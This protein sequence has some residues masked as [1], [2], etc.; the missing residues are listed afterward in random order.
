MTRRT[1][2]YG[3]DDG[4]EKEADGDVL[5]LAGFWVGDGLYGIDIMRIKEVLQAAPHPV[6][7]V[8]HAADVI[9]GVISLRGVVIP[10]LDLRKRFGVAIDE[11]FTRL[12]KLVIVSVHGRIVGLRVDRVLGE[13]RVAADAVRPAPSMLNLGDHGRGEGFFSGVCRVGEHVVFVLNLDGLVAGGAS[14]SGGGTAASGGGGG[15]G[16]GAAGGGG[17][18]NPRGRP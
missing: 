9:E 12:N 14:P 10:I 3:W 7:P 8:P 16:G 5:K 1:A 15:T 18:R 4:E 6:R 2:H 17:D 11:A 13:L